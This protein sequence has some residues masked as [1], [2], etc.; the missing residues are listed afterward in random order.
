M[1]GFQKNAANRKVMELES[2][3]TRL[4]S[5]LKQTYN[6]TRPKTAGFGGLIPPNRAEMT[7]GRSLNP[8][9]LKELGVISRDEYNKSC[10][11]SETA[12]TPCDSCSIVQKSFRQS[13]EI[14]VNI[15][16]QQ[17]IP[18]CLQKFRPQVSHL[19]WLS[20]ND[21]S[22]WSAEQNKDLQRIS[23][24]TATIQPMKRELSDCSEKCDKLEK[25][26]TNFDR[27]LKRER[28]E[29]SALHNQY[30]MKIKEIE[31][32]HTKTLEL[33][34]QQRDLLAL[35]KQELEKLLEKHKSELK[36]QQNLLQELGNVLTLNAPIATKVVCFSRLLK[37]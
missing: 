4:D 35:N 28:D 23:K 11:T 19:D 12:F 2:D 34:R 17:Q 29:R 7:L 8:V 16:Q 18:S 32:Q 25:R 36:E 24:L 15:C 14:I 10:Q 26:V 3:N 37:C 27:D 5:E 21:V 13:G 1:F 6:N 22:R 9:Q 30:E 31:S 20:G 33:E